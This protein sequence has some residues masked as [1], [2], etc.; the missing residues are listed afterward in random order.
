MADYVAKAQAHRVKRDAAIPKEYLIDLS[1]AGVPELPEESLPL[2]YSKTEPHHPEPTTIY[3]KDNVTSVPSKVLSP[4]DVTITE[5]PIDKLL[6]SLA[7]GKLSS[8]RCTEA[9]LRRAVLAHQLTNC[10]TDFFP[11]MAFTRAKECDEYLAKNKKPI[12]LLHGLPVSLKDQ[13]LI[14]DTIATMGY[15]AWIDNVAEKNSVITDV[16]LGAGAVLYVRTSIPQSLMRCETHNHIYG[17]TVSPFNRSFTP[18]GSS[19]GEGALVGM[20]GSPLGLGT[21]IG[22]SVRVPSAFN[23]LWGMRPSMHRIPYEGA[24]NSFQGQE[25]VSSV[26][27]PLTHSLEGVVTFM[28]AVLAQR[29]WELDPILVSMPFNE[30]AYALKN[31]QL[32]AGSA[33]PAEALSSGEDKTQQLCFAIE[34]DD[35]IIHPHPPI[36]R[37][38]REV[39]EKLIAAGHKVIDWAPYDHLRCYDIISRIYSAD[40]GEDIKRTC[41]EGGEPVMYNLMSDGQQPKHLSTYESWQVNQEKSR[42]RKEYLDYWQNTKS[43]TGTGRPVD[44]IIAPV[45]NWAS[46]KHDLNDHVSYTTQ[47]NLL[48]RPCVVFPVSFVDPQKDSKVPLKKPY[49]ALPGNLDAVYWDRYDP[50]EWAG[51]PVNLQV[52]GKRLQ[53]EE[54][55]GLARVIRDAGATLH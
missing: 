14:K 30:D 36:T 54:L 23:G 20:H 40:G 45:S 1:A 18:G 9:F 34:W 50:E 2:P 48:D 29:P 47:W 27:G 33:E 15:V 46:C 19:G 12:G 8:V 11:E 51:M 37:A 31:L 35:G 32:K 41:D 13:F 16:M 49:T 3:P 39:K 21:D 4:E 17:R 7:N 38:L 44:G 10:A 43:Q 5:T 42:Y 28:R 53:D 55:L 25:S 26:I 22:G 6:E 52:V 24:A